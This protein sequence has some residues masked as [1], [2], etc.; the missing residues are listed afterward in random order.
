MTDQNENSNSSVHYAAIGGCRDTFDYVCAASPVPI[1]AGNRH[2]RTP[3]LWCAAKNHQA[4]FDHIVER[5][6]ADPLYGDSFDKTAL[7]HACEKGHLDLA[8]H[9][10]ETYGLAFDAVDNKGANCLVWT[11]KRNH[12]RLFDFLVTERGMDPNSADETGAPFYST[13]AGNWNCGPPVSC[14]L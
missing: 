11:V 1:T 12:R 7:H 13:G 8:L 6:G 9:L 4:L 14:L 10:E 2:N 3:L 5:Y